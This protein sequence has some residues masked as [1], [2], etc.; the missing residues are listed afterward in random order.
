MGTVSLAME[1]MMNG[2]VFTAV[3]LVY[4][5]VMG[6]WWIVILHLFFIGVVGYFSKDESIT[7]AYSLITTLLLQRFSHLPVW[8]DYITS[9]IIIISIAILLYNLVR[10]DK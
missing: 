10:G 5:T 4:T 3:Y 2:S 6:L 7:A 9:T 8:A 1:Y